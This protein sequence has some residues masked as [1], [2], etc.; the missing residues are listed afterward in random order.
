M[1]FFR[2]AGDGKS[3]SENYR[4]S[5]AVDREIKQQELAQ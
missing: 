4:T 3:G 5:K 1:N 2:F